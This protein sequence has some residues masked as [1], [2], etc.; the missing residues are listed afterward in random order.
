MRKAMANLLKRIKNVLSLHQ[1]KEYEEAVA[2]VVAAIESGKLKS[3]DKQ[4]W[5][6]PSSIE[7][8]RDGYHLLMAWIGRNSISSRKNATYRSKR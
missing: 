7:D 6:F 1:R 3:D 5:P 8:S 2:R 4:L